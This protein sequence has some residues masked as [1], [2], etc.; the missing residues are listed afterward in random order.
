MTVAPPAAATGRGLMPYSTP[1]GKA[2]LVERLRD[3]PVESVLDVG[4]GCGTYARL[5]R[6]LFPG[7]RFEAVEIWEPYI[8]RFG[9]RELYE[10]VHVADAVQ[11]Y[12]DRSY[13]LAIFGDV[14]EHVSAPGGAELVHRL[15]THLGV[16]SVPIIPLPQGAEEGNPYEAH[17]TEWTAQEVLA[18]FPVVA[19]HREHYAFGMFMLDA[20]PEARP[21]AQ[22]RPQAPGT[23]AGGRR[24]GSAGDR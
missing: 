15:V 5:L 22:A 23:C 3:M 11:F 8:D 19:W 12:P 24:P 10:V 4:A 21:W 13:D 16:I 2:W 1:D 14:I 18:T 20:R 17:I 7:A 9:L 6:P